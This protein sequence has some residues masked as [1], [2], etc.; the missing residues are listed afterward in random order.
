[1]ISNGKSVKS[2]KQNHSAYKT[3]SLKKK[4]LNNY[5]KII[6]IIFKKIH[7]QVKRVIIMLGVNTQERKGERRRERKGERRRERKGERR[8]ERKP[9]MKELSQEDPK[10]VGEF[11]NLSHQPVLRTHTKVY[12]V[13][14]TP[15]STDT[16]QTAVLD[17]KK[18][19]RAV[20]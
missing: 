16:V 11:T 12:L 17:E 4:I 6:K 19:W 14:Q 18:A 8:N 2:C 15:K 20:Q 10:N 7:T 5:I 3:H 13:I 9:K 1:M